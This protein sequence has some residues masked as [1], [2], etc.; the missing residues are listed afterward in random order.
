M[1][2]ALAAKKS[3]RVGGLYVQSVKIKVKGNG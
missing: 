2:W 1:L 3:D